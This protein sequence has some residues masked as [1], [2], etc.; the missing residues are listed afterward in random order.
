MCQ[1]SY[2]IS[3]SVNLRPNKS[4]KAATV[5]RISSDG[6][7]GTASWLWRIFLRLMATFLWYI[8]F[9]ADLPANALAGDVVIFE[10]PAL[11]GLAGNF[12]VPPATK[13]P[14]PSGIFSTILWQPNPN[15]I[16]GTLYPSTWD[17]GEKT[18]FH[19][20]PPVS[21]YSGSFRSTTGSSTLQIQGDTIGVYLNSADLPAGSPGMKFMITP[22]YTIPKEARIHP[23]A[24]PEVSV[25]ATLELQIP[26]A[27]DEQVKRNNTYA[28]AVLLFTDATSGTKLS[29]TGGFF[30]N[31]HANS[32]ENIGY[33]IPTQSF[34]IQSPLRTN[35]TWTTM[36]PDSAPQQGTPWLGWKKFNFA[37]TEE[38]FKTALLAVKNAAPTS[39]ASMNPADYSLD[40]FHLNAEMHFQ[41]NA[42]PTELG[43]SMRNA[44]MFIRN[45]K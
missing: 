32:R 25:I 9:F 17:A 44:R 33:D 39:R 20:Q 11:D 7:V 21:N 34:M 41:T 15:R 23:F 19:L 12:C 3:V 2:S 8:F 26:T 10:Q 18:G 4:P 24:T 45:P 27:V 22:Q 14:P 13:Q 28:N 37:I 40:H 31:G 29:Y 16:D 5:D 42:A 43:W 30:F 6:K 38:N 1:G 35:S 36:L